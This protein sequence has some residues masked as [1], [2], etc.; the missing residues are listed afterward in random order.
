VISPLFE[1]GRP[2]PDVCYLLHTLQ[3][4]PEFPVVGKGL[5][6]S[7]FG[8][9]FFAGKAHQP[10]IDVFLI[11]KLLADVGIPSIDEVFFEKAPGY[12]GIPVLF[13]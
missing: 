1:V 13:H 7:F 2:N 10:L 3:G 4:L 6:K 9:Q 12:F 11:E 8:F 5:V